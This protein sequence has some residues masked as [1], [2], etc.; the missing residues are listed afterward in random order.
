MGCHLRPHIED[1]R[2]VLSVCGNGSFVIVNAIWTTVPLI[3]TL[4]VVSRTAHR[5]L[6]LHPES[7]VAP[8]LPLIDPDCS[9]RPWQAAK[10]PRTCAQALSPQCR[11]YQRHRLA[12]LCS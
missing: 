4:I 2:D 7:P 1:Q 9:L 3:S 8:D 5:E 6:T 10:L 12:V 11:A